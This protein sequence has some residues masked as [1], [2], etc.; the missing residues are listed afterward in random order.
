M[1]YRC[2]DDIK[3]QADA[4]KSALEA[5]DEQI[6]AIEALVG[7]SFERAVHLLWLPLLPGTLQ[8]PA[9]ER[10]AGGARERVPLLRSYALPE[11]TLPREGDP[12]LLS[13]SRSGETHGTVKAVE[14][15]A[16]RFPGAP[17]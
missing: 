12:L 8:R 13:A 5:V 2:Y 7:D 10:G 3:N 14:A 6:E 4:W 17:F 15:F 11:A 16:K 9:L 1:S